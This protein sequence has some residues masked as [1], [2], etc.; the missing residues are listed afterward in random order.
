E[1]AGRLM[2]VLWG[3]MLV[4]VAVVI[5]SGLSHFDPALAFDFPAGAW[6]WDASH[7]R[8]LGLALGIA[9][10][11]FLGYY[12]ICYLGDEV[13]DPARTFPR[14][15][16]ISAAVVAVVYLTMNV[17]ILGVVPWR[18][19]VESEHIASTFMK[20]RFGDG[21]ATAITA[22]ILW[23]GTASIFAGVLS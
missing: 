4:T 6:A 17:S 18:E 2:V 7:A 13:T 8:G 3:G 12:Q 21:A 11:D 10:Y 1:V 9:M 14:A 15:I 19:V 22:M 16:L 5:A 20:A 23:T